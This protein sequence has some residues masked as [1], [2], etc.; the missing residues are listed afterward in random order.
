MITNALRHAAMYVVLLLRHAAT[1]VVLLLL[2]ATHAHAA[3][4]YIGAGTFAEANNANVTPT[5]HASHAANDINLI[6][7]AFRSTAG[8]ATVTGYTALELEPTGAK[9]LYLF[10]RVDGGSES[11]PTVAVSGGS[12]GETV[13]AKAYTIRGALVDCGSIVAN[14]TEQANANVDLTVEYPALTITTA[15]TFVGIMYMHNDSHTSDDTPAGFTDTGFFD[16]TL[17]SDTSANLKYQIQTTATNIGAGT[18]TITGGGTAVSSAIV[19]ALKEASASTFPT[20]ATESTSEE[21]VN[22]TAHDVAMPSGTITGNQIVCAFGGDG[23]PSA[24]WPAEWTELTSPD[25]CELSGT[26]SALSVARYNADGTDPSA[27][28]VTTDVAEKSVHHCWRISRHST[29]ITPQCEILT[30]ASATTHSSPSLTP[31]GGAK[32]YLWL[33][34][35]S[36]DLGDN[37][38][39]T[40]SGFPASYVSTGSESNA[41][42]TGVMLGWARRELNAASEDPGN[43]T[44]SVAE[45]AIVATIAIHPAGAASTV[46]ITDADTDESV[47]ATQVDFT[48][49][50][51]GFGTQGAGSKVEVIQGATTKLLSSAGYTW[52]S[53]TITGV[54]MSGAGCGVVNGLLG[55]SA[56]LRV[57]AD[58]GAFDDMPITITAPSGTTYFNLSGGVSAPDFANNDKNSRRLLG[59]PLDIQS[60]SQCCARNVQGTGTCTINADGSLTATSTVTACDVDCSRDGLYMGTAAPQTLKEPGPSFGGIELPAF[61]FIKDKP[62]VA[63][64][65]DPFFVAGG[66]AITARAHKQIGTATDSTANV[67]GTQTLVASLAVDD[68]SPLVDDVEGYIGCGTTAGVADD[69]PVQ[70]YAADPVANTLLLYR[71]LTCAANDN[72]YTFAVG[73]ASI[74]GLTLD[75]GTGVL[76]GTPT[77]VAEHAATMFRVTASD[78]SFADSP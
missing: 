36:V 1:Y 71:P 31:T 25:T 43:F 27:I 52:G 34:I 56:T 23:A 39:I 64:D 11:N 47:T 60:N 29:S 14:V 61:K 54:D 48:I 28:I 10:C 32:D 41:S 3:I 15:N 69:N 46:E 26:S 6:V 42:T 58:G 63:L 4:T 16:S 78:G 5:L 37:A 17:G 53:T 7:A 50:G 21:T 49:T 57:T 9:K 76:S 45:G 70:M 59:D 19:F 13:I 67:N 18:I 24:A 65:I 72:V 77:T 38:N 22:T 30:S 40:I 74:L 66:T 33:T 73:N 8:S 51:T 55:G 44:L 35:A 2:C 20:V 68:A 62:I 12:A 75:S